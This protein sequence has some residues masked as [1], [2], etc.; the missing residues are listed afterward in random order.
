[1]TVLVVLVGLGVALIAAGVVLAWRRSAARPSQRSKTGL[2]PGQEGIA[3]AA[4]ETV[5]DI[6]NHRLA[7]IPGLAGTRVDFV[8]AADETLEIWIGEERFTSVDEIRDDRVRQA[9]QDAVA[10][11]NR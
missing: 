2:P 9:V 10:E 4:S 1:M 11:F 3:S 5:E 6:V 8:T 7:T